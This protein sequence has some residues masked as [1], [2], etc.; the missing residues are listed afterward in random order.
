[1]SVRDEIVGVALWGVR[2]QARIHYAPVRPIPL[3]RGLPL[4]TDCSGFAT[5][6]YFLAGAPDPN[7]LDYIGQGYTG[8]LLRHLPHVAQ[9]EI[10]PGDL[11]VW[12]RY[13]GR[14]C[15][16][17][18]EPGEDPLLV[19]HGQERGPVELRFSDEQAAQA[20]PV[21]WLRGVS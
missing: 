5:L 1:M 10:R 4:T 13:P 8:T 17:V 11:V 3:R 9:D 20:P 21:T 6:C 2:M 14:H 16:V 7:G 12:G 15:A 18:V 19:S